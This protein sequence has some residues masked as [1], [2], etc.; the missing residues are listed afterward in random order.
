MSHSP[1]VAAV[2]ESTVE[3]SNTQHPVASRVPTVPP[4]VGRL[5]RLRAIRPDDYPSLF[6]IA[7]S[8]QISFRWRY[9][10]SIPDF[11]TFVQGLNQGVLCQ[12]AVSST[13]SDAIV[14]LVCAY[15][16]DN[17][18]GHCFLAVVMADRFVATGA[19]VEAVAL[20]TN[21]VFETWPMR[22]MY[23]EAIDFAYDQY[24]SGEG[25][26]FR[27]EGCL[28]EHWYYAGQW[29]DEHMLAIYREDVLMYRKTLIP[30]LSRVD[31]P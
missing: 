26:I 3:D 9:R 28:K 29:W 24:R 6:D 2:V 15:A 12:F 11:G 23:F 7:M 10:G 22:K 31:Y 30:A 13:T 17:R 25:R 16:A 8:E 20:F 27:R 21:Y 5:V 4:L 18:N 1:G 19:G 14:G